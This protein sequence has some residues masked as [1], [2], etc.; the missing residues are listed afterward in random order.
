MIQKVDL[1]V[2]KVLSEQQ[3]NELKEAGIEFE[4]GMGGETIKDP[5]LKA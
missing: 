1:E 2:G 4:A 3:Y 5:F